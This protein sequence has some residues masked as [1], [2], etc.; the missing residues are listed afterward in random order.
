LERHGVPLL[1]DV[2]AGE[3]P[4]PGDAALNLGQGT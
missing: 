2:E 4:L 1:L 3:R